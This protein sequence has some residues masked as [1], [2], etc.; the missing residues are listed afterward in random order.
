MTDNKSP[1][2]GWKLTA[3]AVVLTSMVGAGS[4]AVA[5]IND[6]S[7]TVPIL[8]GDSIDSSTTVT[9]QKTF[10]W[11]ESCTITAGGS[12]TASNLVLAK[13]T[14][15]TVVVRATA[16]KGD[17]ATLSIDALHCF[18][19]T[20]TTARITAQVDR[21]LLLDVLDTVDTDLPRIVGPNQ[22]NVRITACSTTTPPAST[23]SQSIA[24]IQVHVLDSG[25]FRFS[26]T[27]EP[28]T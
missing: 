23:A 27:I 28:V 13:C 8:I 19:A 11:K 7:N 10:Q 4:F 18:A 5:T 17:T 21:G 3:I 12:W 9:T 24:L 6:P 16:T 15:H 14:K 1:I 26:L 20:A 2:K 25:N 22:W